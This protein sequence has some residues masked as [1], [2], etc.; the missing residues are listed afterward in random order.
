M[1]DLAAPVVNAPAKAFRLEATNH[2]GSF[3]GKNVTPAKFA[4]GRES[5]FAFADILFA[6]DMGTDIVFGDAYPD[7]RGNLYDISMIPDMST[8]VRWK[9]GVDS[10][11]GDFWLKDGRPV[12]I[13]PRN[14][15]RLLIDRLAALG[16]TATVAVEIET[17][18]FEESIQEARA[19]GYRG[20]TPL[21][22]DTGSTYCL[23]RSA[24]WIDYMEAV[25]DRLDQLGI[26]WE[27]WTDEAAP[28]QTELNIAPTEPLALADA[29]VRTKQVMR[30]IACEKGCSVT[31]MAKPTAGFGQ[32]A[33]INLSLQRDGVNQFYSP[34]GPSEVMLQAVGGLMATMAGNTLLALPQITSYRRLVDVSGPP[35]TIS[36]GVNNKTA[37]LR[38]IA[39]HPN[40]SRLEYR[41]PGSD[42]NPYYALAGV[43][44]GVIAG[45]ER[46][47]QAPPQVDD[48]A[49]CLP[50]YC[51]VARI[52]DSITKAIAALDADEILR[53]Y[54]GDE[55]VDFW[56]ASRRWEWMEFHTKGGDP[57]TELSEWESRRYFEFS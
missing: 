13:C 20:L 30:E 49:W 4:S 55:F 6:I 10:V 54:L 40:Y 24:D 33:H 47:M 45:I 21:G 43:L 9:P 35:T 50:D 2:D 17:T 46:K 28:G 36:W 18:L 42:V 56:T 48:M 25:T 53:E 26:V 37:A 23:A 22:G 11:I 15:V 12:P 14:M 57:Y 29:W 7:W 52:P 31:F 16:Y 51:G 38:A 19:R 3:M 32:G 1:S 39:G 27:A 8:L 44:A 5:G 34:D 41:V